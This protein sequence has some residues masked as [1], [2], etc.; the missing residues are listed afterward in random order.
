MFQ[1]WIWLKFLC[2]NDLETK[3]VTVEK[4][5]NKY[6][7]ITPPPFL[8]CSIQIR[9]QFFLLPFIFPFF[10]NCLLYRLVLCLTEKADQLNRYYQTPF[11]A[12]RVKIQKAGSAH[13]LNRCSIGYWKENNSPYGYILLYIWE[14]ICHRA[15][16]SLACRVS[17]LFSRRLLKDRCL[18]AQALVFSET[19]ALHKAELSF[20]FNEKKKK[21]VHFMELF[22][23]L[24]PYF[25]R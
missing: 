15:R 25:S 5:I 19:T 24:I 23:Q 10:I 6:I 3:K 7:I 9:S 8:L 22:L 13:W 1:T 18:A 2:C 14:Q 16:G 4:N 17:L 12:E 11:I 21:N 20:T